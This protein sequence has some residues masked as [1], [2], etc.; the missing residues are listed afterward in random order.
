[1]F[2]GA[3]DL[4]RIE[5]MLLADI[6][7]FRLGDQHGEVSYWSV[8]RHRKLGNVKPKRWRGLWWL[9]VEDLVVGCVL[10]YFYNQNASLW[11][12][13]LTALIYSLVALN[14]VIRMESQIE[15]SS[16]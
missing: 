8:H 13:V 11:W 10:Y 7:E 12:L 14:S 15:R 6:S 1:M 3:D 2:A 5:M 16:S 9:A 4:A